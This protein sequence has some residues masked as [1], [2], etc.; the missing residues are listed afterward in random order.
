MLQLEWP[1]VLLALPL[2]YL[3]RRF[4]PVLARARGLV[5]KV[6]VLMDYE[7]LTG[8]ARG[9]GRNL[10]PLLV[11]ASAWLLLICAATRPQRLGEPIDV[12][13]SGR[14][15]MLAIDLSE[16]M[17]ET[18]FVVDSRPVNRLTATKA[19]AAEFIDKRI[20]DRIGLILFGQQ[21][22][23][24]VPLTFDRTTVK[25]LL[26]E[27]VIGMAGRQTAIGDALG[28]AVKRLREE[29]APQKVLILMTDGRNSAGALDP[30]RAATL[31]GDAGLT[32]HTIGIGADEA[33][34]S[35]FF[36]NARVNSGT[37]LDEKTLKQIATLTGGRYYPARHTQGLAEIY[38]ELDKLEVVEH[39]GEYYRPRETLYFWPLGGATVIAM[40][41]TGWVRARGY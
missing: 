22:Y 19:V 14:D 20:G 15:L 27:A 33:L 23:L 12:A 10:A 24:H 25:S 5:L 35:N 16:S 1:S 2:P 26:D 3:I 31:A 21:A 8:S 17:R 37:D 34:K 36:D 9:H 13:V 18:D 11:A 28:L 32:V 40:A 38:A 6:P 7:P 29:D 39:G 41:L 30:L 4:S